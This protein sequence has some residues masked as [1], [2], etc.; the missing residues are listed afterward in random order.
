MAMFDM[1]EERTIQKKGKTQARASRETI[2]ELA[3]AAGR[4]ERQFH[5]DTLRLFSR[6]PGDHLV[7]LRIDRAAEYLRTTDYSLA[8]IA[9]L[10]G[11]K[12]PYS[13]ANTYNRLRGRRPSEDRKRR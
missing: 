2:A 13:L 4:S 6:T 12:N 3:S 7:R 10:V 5:R 8:V 11:V 1:T 9:E